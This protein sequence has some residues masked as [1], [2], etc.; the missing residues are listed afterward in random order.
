MI[1]VADKKDGSRMRISPVW[2]MR[3]H[4]NKGYARQAV[5][6]GEKKYRAGNRRPETVF[7]E[8]GDLHSYEKPG[9]HRTGRIEKTNRRMD[10][11]I[12]EKV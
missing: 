3:E 4:R 9:F 8:K 1:R 5:L 10:T 12:Y 2:I 7:Q 11:V 6:E